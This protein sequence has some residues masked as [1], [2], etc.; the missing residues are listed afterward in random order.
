MAIRQEE[1]LVREAVV[2]RFPVEAI[3]SRRR[4]DALVRRRR[5]VAG[6][7]ALVISAGLL[8]AWSPGPAS[9]SGATRARRIVVAPGETLWDI[10]EAHAPGSMDPRVYVDEVQSLNRLQGPV[11]PGMRLKLP[12]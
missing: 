11:R 8:V 1:L 6:V 12:G 4:R 3:T 10:A 5:T 9:D 7:L 2:Y